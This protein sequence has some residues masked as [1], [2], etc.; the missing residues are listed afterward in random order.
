MKKILSMLCIFTGI[1]LYAQSLQPKIYKISE[2]PFTKN[3]KSVEKIWKDAD[4]LTGFTIPQKAKMAIYQTKASMLYDDTNLYVKV[5]RNF[6]PATEFKPG[7][8]ISPFSMSNI[9]F[10]IRPDMKTEDFFQIC[11]APGCDTYTSA[12]FRAAPIEGLKV[13]TFKKNARTRAFNFIIPLKSIGLNNVKNGQKAGFNICG[14]NYDV[15]RYNNLSYEESSF[16]VLEDKNFRRPGTWNNAVFTTEKGNGRVITGAS[17]DLK[18]NLFA[19]SDFRYVAPGVKGIPGWDVMGFNKSVFRQELLEF[20]NNWHLHVES[21]SFNFLRARGIKIVPDKEYTIKLKARS[22][23]GG[24]QLN[25]ELFKRIDKRYAKVGVVTHRTPVTKDFTTYT[26]IFKSKYPDPDFLFYRIGPRKGVSSMDVKD[27]ELYEGRLSAFEVRTVNDVGVKALA[28]GTERPIP[29]NPMGKR[30]SSLKVL[31]FTWMGGYL[32]YTRARE[33]LEIFSGTGAVVDILCA[34][35][36]N[37]DAYYTKNDIKTIYNRLEKGEYDAYLIFGNPTLQRIGTETASIVAKN[38]EKGAVLIIQDGKAKHN[39]RS[40]L[41]KYPVKKMKENLFALNSLDKLVKKRYNSPDVTTSCGNAGK[42]KIYQVRIAATNSVFLPRRDMQEKKNFHFPYEDY[43]KAAFAAAVYSAAGKNLFPVTSLVYADDTFFVTAAN[44][45]AKTSFEWEILHADGTKTASGRTLLNAGKGV[46]FLKN[47]SVRSGKNLLIVRTFDEKG[48]V[49]DYRTLIFDKKGTLLNLDNIQPDNVGKKSGRVKIT[50][51]GDIKNA[52]VHWQ[53]KDFSGRTLEKGE[54]D[55][56]K[57]KEVNPSFK[58]VFT[59]F[60]T[61]RAELVKNNK[62]VSSADMTLLVQDKD[63]ERVFSD[64]FTLR[65]WDMGDSEGTE[66]AKREVNYQ[67]EKVGVNFF[68]PTLT[69]DGVINQADGM[70]SGT[71]FAGDAHNFVWGRPDKNNPNIRDRTPFS[72]A[73]RKRINEVST[74][75]AK[76]ARERGYI[77]TCLCDEPNLCWP[78]SNYEFDSHPENIAE[79]RKRMKEKYG[80]IENFN[81]KMGS[82]WTSFD[83]IMPVLTLEARKTGRFGEFIQ[84]R[85]FNIDRWCE[86]IRLVRDNSKKYAPFARF[87]LTNSFGQGIYSGNDYAKLYRNT[88]IDYAQ[89]YVSIGSMS[90]YPIRNFDEFMRSFNSSILSWGAV[91]FQVSFQHSSFNPWWYAAHRYGGMGWY[92]VTSGSFNMIDRPSMGLTIDAVNLK[93]VIEKSKLQK[94][95]G[96]LF[97][98][99]NWKK[100]DIAI[101][102]SQTSMQVAFLLGTEKRNNYID[103]KSPLY[104]Y[105]HSRQAVHFGLEALLY[106]YDFIP[107]MDVEKGLLKNYKTLFMPSIISMSDKEVDAVKEFMAKGGKVIA[108]FAPGM[109]DELGNKRSAP[110]LPGVMLTGKIFDEKTVEGRLLMQKMLAKTASRPIL[111]SKDIVSTPGREVM[112]F[113]DGVNSVFVIL[114]NFTLSKDNKTQTFTFPAKGHVYNLRTGKYLGFTDNVTCAVPNAD[115]VV[116]GVYPAKVTALDVKVPARVRAGKDLAAKISLA[117]KGGKTGKRVYH[118]EVINPSGKA[119]FFMKRNLVSDNGKADFVF[120][121]ADNDPEGI[122]TLKVTDVLTAVSTE[123]K[124]TLE[125]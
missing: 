2:M 109:Y 106:Q 114:R 107:Y 46:V 74:R 62:V 76:L 78:D 52:K 10:F 19:N 64:G 15:G 51:S 61:F 79:F 21:G 102:Y 118:V 26:F 5:E 110:P 7:K 18:V 86:V 72:A 101:Y 42:G 33:I 38:V 1:C 35:N 97:L 71:I 28:K 75:V 84:W 66:S 88:G 116:F 123:K 32:N 43:T 113:T 23:E 45:P 98:A 16:S 40:F 57:D 121:M 11:A 120:R 55:A 125:K 69:F 14:A 80:S 92:A 124:F 50:L 37:T 100:N 56:V 48:A 87:A 95:L 36:I 49:L 44:V 119:R 20:S 34:Q 104:N 25:I 68:N 6:E 65:M 58:H 4:I 91:G 31:A 13:Y 60:N 94:G 3:G 122:W 8:K 112:H 47:A 90:K 103:E 54:Y 63:A 85:N 53:L 27:I 22:L 89:E 29:P 96:K 73:N 9:E 81:K 82:K 24:N 12:G 117:V 70:A 17:K 67:L 93:N 59:S 30:A 115:A 105:F 41:K 108:D 39:L 111:E 99:Y 77:S 83:E